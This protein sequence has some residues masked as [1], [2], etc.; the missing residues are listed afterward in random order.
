MTAS[1]AQEEAVCHRLKVALKKLKVRLQRERPYLNMEFRHVAIFRDGDLS[2]PNF[3]QGLM[4]PKNFNYSDMK[5]SFLLRWSELSKSQE[6]S[7]NSSPCEKNGFFGFAY[8]LLP[9]VCYVPCAMPADAISQTP[10][11]QRVSF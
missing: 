11:S 8:W 6:L 7:K 4:D 3:L 9:Q 1:C 5:R 10:D 2:N